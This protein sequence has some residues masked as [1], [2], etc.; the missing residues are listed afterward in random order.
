M[1][2]KSR[3]IPYGD[4]Q[5]TVGKIYNVAI[6]ARLSLKNSG[7]PDGDSIE[8]QIRMAQ[9]F[10]GDH[11]NLRLVATFADN[12]ETGTNFNRPFFNEM[13]DAVKSGKINCIIVKDL[14]R[15]GR[16]YI[17]TGNY[18]EKIFPFL[19]VRFISITDNYD[20]NDPK[21]EGSLTLSLKSLVN[22]I[23][24]KDISKK[25]SSTMLA[26]QKNGV[27]I[28]NHA[29]YGYKKSETAKGKLEIDPLAASVVKEIFAMKL[30][31]VANN[32]IAKQL[33]ERG[34]PSPSN[35]R[36][37][38]GIIK[39]DKYANSLWQ[40][41]TVKSILSNPV[42]TGCMS[43]GKHKR[44]LAAGMPAM[45]TAPDE[46]IN[47][48]DMH[49]AIVDKSTFDAV[50]AMMSTARE[51]HH[52]RRSF[53]HLGNAE[54]IFK[55]VLV[56]AECGANLVR[57]KDVRY[58]QK[59]PSVSYHFH[60]QNYGHNSK[61]TT[62]KYVKEKVLKQVIW[63]IVKSQMD[64][65]VDLLSLM[66]KLK[67]SPAY[68]HNQNKAKKRMADI[69]T[70]LS[71]IDTRI[72][73]SYDSYAE[74][75]LS[76]QEYSFTKAKYKDEKAA[77]ECELDEMRSANEQFCESKWTDEF[78]IFEKSDELTAELINAVISRVRV[79]GRDELSV[80]FRHKDVCRD[81]MSKLAELEA[82]E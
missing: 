31:N 8:N 24:A 73:S 10:I 12:G 41:Q 35:Y 46:W 62:R 65:Q 15:F 9:D 74:G 45:R 23:Y 7:K 33:N 49:D 17:E 64:I 19:G 53:A 13:M 50:T 69:R 40:Q 22:D 18:L 61:C 6:Y 3:K 58:R 20:S 34:V 2:R 14:S 44:S 82:I 81:L 25:V 21:A 30:E 78:A 36:Q 70:N 77:L 71:H 52:N 26:R 39:T 4:V 56:C 1:P 59:K 11:S 67:N 72:A 76:E 57:Y 37:K 32:Q 16:N 42:Y 55:G 43:Q 68:K 66:Q 48:P 54:N 75:V 29:P 27:F 60:C 38:L 79:S 28:G 51:E 5:L 47:V 80:E 63:E